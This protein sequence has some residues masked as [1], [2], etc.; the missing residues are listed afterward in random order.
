MGSAS[1]AVVFSA[2]M[3]D[4]PSALGQHQRALRAARRCAF[5]NLAIGGLIVLS[6]VMYFRTGK[7]LYG[8]ITF[9]TLTGVPIMIREI[10]R[11]TRLR[12]MSPLESTER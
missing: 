12:S 1:L 10:R 3:V 8:Q 4:V 6:A 5:I 9:A 11:W 2:A 7:Q